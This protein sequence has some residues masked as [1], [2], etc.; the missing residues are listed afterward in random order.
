MGGRN[1][2]D[3]DKTTTVDPHVGLVQGHDVTRRG[4][5]CT[6]A[7]VGLEERESLILR[8][9]SSGTLLGVNEIVRAQSAL[10][11]LPRL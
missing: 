3:G 10:V 8:C 2:R 11:L 5:I 4:L 1:L 7:G 6:T 9:A